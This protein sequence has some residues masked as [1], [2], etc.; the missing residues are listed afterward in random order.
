MT[1]HQHFKEFLRESGFKSLNLVGPVIG[2]PTKDTPEHLTYLML[3][4]DEGWEYRLGLREE[5]FC[6]NHDGTFRS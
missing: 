3:I 6:F 4:G 5:P 1:A 2:G